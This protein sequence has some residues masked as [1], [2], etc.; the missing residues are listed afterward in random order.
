MQTEVLKMAARLES[1][2][3]SRGVE[4][5]VGVA[6]Q[7]CE[8]PA[9]ANVQTSWIKDLARCRPGQ[10]SSRRNEGVKEREA[11]SLDW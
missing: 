10:R 6:R 3:R 8:R 7:K 4:E 5:V 2:R 11:G 1:I 9:I